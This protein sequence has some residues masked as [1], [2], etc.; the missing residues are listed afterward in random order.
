MIPY[1]PVPYIFYKFDFLWGNNF[2][3]FQFEYIARIEYINALKQESRNFYSEPFKCILLQVLEIIHISTLQAFEIPFSSKFKARFSTIPTSKNTQSIHGNT[4]LSK[5]TR[6]YF[7]TLNTKKITKINHLKKR[8][9]SE[10]R[11][12]NGVNFHLVFFFLLH[13]PS[14]PGIKIESCLN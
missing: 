8:P 12:D 5:M 13:V 10:R 3:I 11:E 4:N 9:K 1:K 14:V 6:M 2:T 7:L